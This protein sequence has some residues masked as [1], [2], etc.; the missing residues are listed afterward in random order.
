MGRI[1]NNGRAA[2]SPLGKERKVESMP[3]FFVIF[4]PALTACAISACFAE[5]AEMAETR[6]LAAEWELVDEAAVGIA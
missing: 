6:V 3:L 1:P 2:L 5:L 4:F